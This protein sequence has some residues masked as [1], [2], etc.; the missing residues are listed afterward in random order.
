MA[1]RNNS[2]RKRLKG[3]VW[4]AVNLKKSETRIE[5]GRKIEN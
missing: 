2:T 5:K 4:E 3:S 1:D